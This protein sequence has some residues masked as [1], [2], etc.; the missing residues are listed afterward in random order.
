M[1]SLND[2]D[3]YFQVACKVVF[4]NTECDNINYPCRYYSTKLVKL[5]LANCNIQEVNLK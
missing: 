2:T 3:M 5:S 4:F 1:H